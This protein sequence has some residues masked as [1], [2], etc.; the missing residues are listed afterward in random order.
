M[1]FDENVRQSWIGVERDP[2][3]ERRSDAMRT[4][5]YCRQQ[6][7]GDVLLAS[8]KGTHASRTTF[9]RAELI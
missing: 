5:T 9:K 2:G 4:A 8:P 1:D 7:A 6:L 3:K